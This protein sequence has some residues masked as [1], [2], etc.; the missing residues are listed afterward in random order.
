MNEKVS[1][2][3]KLWLKIPV[4]KYCVIKIAR[5]IRWKNIII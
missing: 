2:R 1:T 3:T 4:I 5:G